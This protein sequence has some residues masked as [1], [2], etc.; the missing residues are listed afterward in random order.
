MLLQMRAPRQLV[1]DMAMRIHHCRRET[2]TGPTE[3]AGKIRLRE[4]E[5]LRGIHEEEERTGQRASR[6]SREGQ[7]EIDKTADGRPLVEVPRIVDPGN[8]LLIIKTTD[9]TAA[10]RPVRI[11][12]MALSVSAAQLTCI[13]TGLGFDS[14]ERLYPDGGHTTEYAH[15]NKAQAERRNPP[16]ARRPP[17]TTQ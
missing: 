8:R 1:R 6:Q 17:S 9:R 11:F 16:I 5:D 15:N 7:E 2:R 4:R 3:G 10:Q 14:R 12:N 13:P